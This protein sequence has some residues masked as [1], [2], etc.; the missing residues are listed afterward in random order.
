MEFLFPT[1]SCS[2][3]V[4]TKDCGLYETIKKKLSPKLDQAIDDI[5]LQLTEDSPALLRGLNLSL[6]Y[7]D[8]STL[9]TPTHSSWTL[10]NFYLCTRRR[11]GSCFFD[12]CDNSKEESDCRAGK[13]TPFVEIALREVKDGCECCANEENPNQDLKAKAVCAS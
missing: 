5:S 2:T 6:I 7:L 11:N 9:P 3:Q 8:L 1:P 10:L 12:V 4:S 13:P